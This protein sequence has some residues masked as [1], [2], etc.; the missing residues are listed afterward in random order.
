MK[1][2]LSFFA[3]VV[4]ASLIAIPAGAE[5]ATED[6][7]P[8]ARVNFGRV[9]QDPL[10]NFRGIISENAFLSATGE[11]DDWAALM[12][13]QGLYAMPM[14]EYGINFIPRVIVPVVAAPPLS[15][16]PILGEPRPEGGSTE[17]G[18]SDIIVQSFIGPSDPGKVIWGIGPKFSLNTHTDEFVRGAGWGAGASGVVVAKL[19]QW[20]LTGIAAHLWGFDGDFSTTMVR[21]FISYNVKSWPGFAIATSPTITYDWE[22]ESGDRW[23][24]PLGGGVTQAIP[25]SATSALLVGLGAYKY[26]ATP[27]FGPEWSINLTFALMFAPDVKK[28]KAAKP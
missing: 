3:I 24:V 9:L 27:E 6:M 8:A 2:T 25:F 26:V 17:W 5:D 7:I 16:L 1:L 14:P 21:P 13:F 15:D 11:D 20:G 18:M 23:S 12:K 19:G 22:A 4:C 10:A 28:E